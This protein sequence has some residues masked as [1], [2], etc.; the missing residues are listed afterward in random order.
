MM[1]PDKPGETSM[2]SMQ[3]KKGQINN[4]TA[5]STVHKKMRFF[6]IKDVY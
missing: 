5:T 6:D 1:F 4:I 2:Q 3:R